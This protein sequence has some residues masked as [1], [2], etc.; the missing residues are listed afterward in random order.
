[1]QNRRIIIDKLYLFFHF[2]RIPNIISVNERYINPS[3]LFYSFISCGTQPKIGLRND[4]N[5]IFK[6][7]YDFFSIV[8]RPIIDDNKFIILVSLIENAFNRIFYIIL[9][10]ISWHYN[11]DCIFHFD[12]RYSKFFTVDHLFDVNFAMIQIPALF[13]DFIQRCSRIYNC[14][15]LKL[16]VFTHTDLH[17]FKL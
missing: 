15:Q 4:F 8:C 17:F 9:S 3:R 12:Y 14:Y 16:Y 10:I 6:L 5:I 1:M 13:L 2:M 11:T 7:F